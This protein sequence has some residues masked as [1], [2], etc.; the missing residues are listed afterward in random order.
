MAATDVT[1]DELRAAIRN[2][3]DFPEQG[4]QFKD[5]TPVLADA[6]LLDGCI[7]NLIGEQT[8]DSV[9]L[10]A[11]IDARGF[12]FGAAM[13]REMGVGFVPIRKKGKLPWETLEESYELEY[14]SNT[15]AIHTD[16][17]SAKQRV[18][19]VDDLLATGGTAAAA[20]SLLAKAGGRVVEAV[21]FIE[22]SF[23]DGRV[24]MGKVPVRS[25]VD[26]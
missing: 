22:L 15:I 13:A 1:L 9:D 19:L 4:I 11:G 7:A 18:L 17:I 3:P 8:A 12:I 10:V 14:G 5:I 24:K 25:L 21:F 16:A 23:L 6:R 20:A 26:Y 2:V